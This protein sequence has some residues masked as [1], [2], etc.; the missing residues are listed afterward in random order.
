MSFD[1]KYCLIAICTLCF[2]LETQG[3]VLSDTMRT[4][5]IPQV[6]V[7]SDRTNSPGAVSVSK[8]ADERLMQATGTLQVSDVIKYMSGATQDRIRK[9][10]WGFT[11]RSC[12]RRNYH[13]R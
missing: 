9:R 11:H 2:H 8:M 3:Q 7:T 1:V 5:D 12:I 6:T 4:K 10:P 13:Y